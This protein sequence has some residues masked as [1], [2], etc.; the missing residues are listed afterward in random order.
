MLE[1]GYLGK[2]EPGKT[3]LR[4]CQDHEEYNSMWNTGGDASYWFEIYTYKDRE[5]AADTRLWELNQGLFRIWR[6]G[7]N[8]ELVGRLPNWIDYGLR[9]CVKTALSK[10]RKVEFKTSS[11][12]N[13]RMGV[14]LRANAKSPVLITARDFMNK[15]TESLWKQQD[16]GLQAEAFARFLLVG[17]SQRNA[18]YKS[19]LSEYLKNF[20]ALVEEESKAEKAAKP[21]D[22]DMKEPQNEE[23]ENAL[24]RERQNRWKEKEHEVLRKLVEKTFAGWDDKEWDAFQKSYLKDLDA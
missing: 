24:F 19:V 3:I 22:D 16:S 23:E 8:E 18:K 17:G 7:K 4:I 12:E 11:G 2:G 10:G 20:V 15:D 14:L 21:D 5:F 9:A 6:K 1:S 13:E